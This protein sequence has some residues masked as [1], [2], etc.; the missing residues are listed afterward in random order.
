MREEPSC[1]SQVVSQTFFSEKID[2]I[3]AQ[4]DW[5]YVKTSDDYL[6]WIP[7]S[8][9][10]QL[11][12]PY[13]ASLKISRLAAHVYAVK[14]IEYG[15]LYTLPYGSRLQA[16]DM[17]DDRWITIRLP[18][19][20]VGCIQKGDIAPEP[21]RS[22]KEDLVELSKNYLGLPYTWGGRSSFGYDCSGFVQM[23][24][25]QIGIQLP[26]DSKQQVLDERFQVINLDQLELGDLIFFGRSEH[27]I[28]HVALY[29]GDG[30]LI[31]ATARENKPWIRISHLSDFE[32]S[33]HQ[34][35]YYPYRT[36]SQFRDR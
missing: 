12:E 7:S 31:H 16:L 11:Q 14:E 13:Y 2:L 19:G 6:G 9:C 1:L 29:M 4:E 23:L 10:V 3:K 34:E 28:R 20:Q 30:Q 25:S 15:P 33:G 24:Y 18:D 36:M 8:A 26:R 5:F 21:K 32:W 22:T 17:A 35:A 27:H